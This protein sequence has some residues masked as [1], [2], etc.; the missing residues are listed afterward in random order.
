M[1]Q[2]YFEISDKLKH[3]IEAQKIF[4][5]DTAPPT[6]ESTYHQRVWIPWK[7]SIKTELHG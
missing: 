6:A 5:V 2:Q 7:F 4:F 1:G 3:F